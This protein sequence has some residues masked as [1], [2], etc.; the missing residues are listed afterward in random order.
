MEN[1]SAKVICSSIGILFNIVSRTSIFLI[2]VSSCNKVFY[3]ITCIHNPSRRCSA[4]PTRYL[5][6]K[7]FDM[8]NFSF[9]YS[10][11]VSGSKCGSVC[12]P[13][14]PQLLPVPCA[15]SYQ[16]GQGLCGCQLG[17]LDNPLCPAI[18]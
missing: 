13:V 16:Y 1:M 12:G 2:A 5:E 7:F 18:L 17:D 9:N 10:V 8:S 15:A 3:A 14:L 4:L 6:R 11:I